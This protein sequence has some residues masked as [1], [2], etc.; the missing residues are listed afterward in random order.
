M[1]EP[2]FQSAAEGLEN[3]L[4]KVVRY[5][6]APD[7]GIVRNA[8]EFAAEA[9]SGQMRKSG[10]P[11]IT[12]PV[13][14][15]DIV[16][17]LKL[18]ELSLCAALLHDTVE[19]TDVTLEDIETR[20]GAEVAALVDGVT[21]LGKVHFSTKKELQAESFRKMLVAMFPWR[22]QKVLACR[23]MAV[24]MSRRS[25]PSWVR[26]H[27]HYILRCFGSW[28]QSAFLCSCCWSMVDFASSWALF[29]AG[30]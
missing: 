24:L 12:H 30:W 15:A 27:C 11:Y 23:S 19:D 7:L 28:A 26:R 8:F 3:V 1:G 18:D 16:A 22:R 5:H 2:R 21:K 13:G 10:E 9:H 25:I 17:S 4:A 6:P 20:F 14:V 29:I